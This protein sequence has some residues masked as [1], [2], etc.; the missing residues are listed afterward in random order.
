[1]HGQSVNRNRMFAGNGNFKV[2]I[3]WLPS[4]SI[5]KLH[6]RYFIVF[7]ALPRLQKP[8]YASDSSNG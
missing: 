1:M 3:I 8:S 5:L 4:T 6:F 7:S 2:A